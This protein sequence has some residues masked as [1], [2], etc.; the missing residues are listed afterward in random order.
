MATEDPC[1]IL[2]LF[3]CET[4][5]YQPPGAADIWKKLDYDLLTP[6]L[7][8]SRCDLDFLLSSETWSWGS[9]ADLC[10]DAGS[11]KDS[12]LQASDALDFLSSLLE[13]HDEAPD[14]ESEQCP[15]VLQDCMWGASSCYELPEP[16]LKESAA[17]PPTPTTDPAL[18]PAGS[19]CD[20][21]SRAP[22]EG[23][24]DSSSVS[25]DESPCPEPRG[26]GRP[27]K[28]PLCRPPS[29]LDTPSD[30]E[31]EIDVV[32]VE[33][34]QSS[35]Y[36]TCQKNTNTAGTRIPPQRTIPPRIAVTLPIHQQHNYAAPSPPSPPAKRPRHDTQRSTGPRACRWVMQDGRM[37]W[38]SS[39]AAGCMSRQSSAGSSGSDSS[40][41]LERRRTHNILERQRRDSLRSCFTRLREQLP[42]LRH[43]P[44]AAKVAVLR[45]AAEHARAL[46]AEENRLH[47]EQKR[48]QARQAQLR[49]RLQKLQPGND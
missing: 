27:R 47:A 26:R 34:L 36:R 44:R 40:D 13:E 46:Q 8:P 5:F 6:P 38:G 39:T 31:E 19:E 18:L 25:A 24:S 17:T 41:D 37:S 15:E 48:L 14:S 12:Q 33:K 35:G 4:S 11:S 28:Q 45:R 2:D 29:G 16:A 30:S 43:Q 49:A 10:G 20:Q 23:S 3:D 7:S 22:S 21:D 32:T 9:V 42:D 1:A